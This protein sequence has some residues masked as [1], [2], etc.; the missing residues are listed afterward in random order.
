M[1]AKIEKW[2][3]EA[4]KSDFQEINTEITGKTL[5]GDGFVGDVVFATVKLSNPPR[6]EEHHAVVVKYGK[7]DPVLRERIPV[8]EAYERETFMYTKAFPLFKRFEED[9]HVTITPPLLPECLTTLVYDQEDVV[10]LRD[11]RSF[12]FEM[13]DK[14]INMD[15]EHLKLTFESYGKFHG[16][17]FAYRDQEPEKFKELFGGLECVQTALLERVK[18]PFNAME[19]CMYDLLEDSE[20][21]DALKR[22]KEKIPE[23]LRRSFLNTFQKQD[24]EERVVLTHGDCWNNNYMFKYEV[25]KKKYKKSFSFKNIET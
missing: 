21:F 24:G 8:K 18:E 22:L 14:L 23:G 17:S 13:R 20:E 25:S 5:Q 12:D 1:S 10:V 19:K 2:L 7:E 3:R 6:Q 15:F 9:H 11:M 16:V 4:F